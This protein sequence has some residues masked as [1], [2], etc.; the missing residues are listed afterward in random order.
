M[1]R[2][3]NVI[4]LMSADASKII[5]LNPIPGSEQR[6]DYRPA[7]QEKKATSISINTDFRVDDLHIV[8]FCGS[9]CKEIGV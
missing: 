4:V 6:S 7:K 9:L 5:S 8:S 2:H 1:K 3:V